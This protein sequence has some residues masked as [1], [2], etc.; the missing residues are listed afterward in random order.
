MSNRLTHG[1]SGWVKDALPSVGK[2]V[3]LALALAL[4]GGLPLV[5]LP[6]WRA[7]DT[8]ASV[9][10]EFDYMV[11]GPAK[12]ITLSTPTHHPESLTFGRVGLE[13]DPAGHATSS[14]DLGVLTWSLEFERTGR[15]NPAA[16]GSALWIFE[17]STELERANLED[18]VR[19]AP[20]W[21]LRSHTN[22]TAGVAV[23]AREDSTEPLRAT[24][25]GSKVRLRL[26][27]HPRG[28]IAWVFVNGRHQE[29]D[30][31]A[32][33][34]SPDRGSAVFQV[35]ESWLSRPVAK[36]GTAQLPLSRDVLKVGSFQLNVFPEGRL[37]IGK[38]TLG[39]L[40]LEV[41]RTNQVTIPVALRS[42]PSRATLSLMTFVGLAVP[43][44]LTARVWTQNTKARVG[45]VLLCQATV[46]AALSGFWTCVFFPALMSPDSLTQWNEALANQYDTWF[47][48]LM[49]MLMHST[50]RISDNPAFFAFCQGSIFWFSLFFCLWSVCPRPRPWLVGTGLLA[51]NPVLWSYTSVLWKDVWTA[52][53]A[54]MTA[55]FAALFLRT[56]ERRHLVA[57]IVAT[58]LAVSFRHNAVLL[59]MVP[60]ALVFR[61]TSWELPARTALALVVCGTLWIFPTLF[62]LPRNVQ[63]TPLKGAAFIEQYVG[64]LVHLKA[65]HPPEYTEEASHFDQHFGGGAA[66][67]AMAGYD[68]TMPASHLLWPGPQRAAILSAPTM[69][70]H[71]LFIMSRIVRLALRHPSGYLRHRWLN[72]RALLQIDAV[73]YPFHRGIDPNALGLSERSLLPR[74]QRAV[75]R[76]MSDKRVTDLLARHFVFVLL[77]LPALAVLWRA[78]SSPSLAVG[79]VGFVYLSSLLICDVSREWRFLLTTYCCSLLV[80]YVAALSLFNRS[81]L[82]VG[83]GSTPAPDLASKQGSPHS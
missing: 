54:L 14:N 68:P 8:P 1:W 76:V 81:P 55:A 2:R 32:G 15:K 49:A 26:R 61:A 13:P 7:D 71:F 67:Q 21:E 57:C 47:P 75:F 64:L 33:P 66:Q 35:D 42:L 51:A 9:D 69:N 77:T 48:P 45:E 41:Q 38:A 79:G 5:L 25:R 6:Q 43:L 29:L 30:L 65:G 39:G 34:G 53:F 20:G 19:S 28:G 10:L 59:A 16:L 63:R 82:E 74:V 80:S 12:E 56:R 22:G 44:F 83:L 78:R 46:A 17:L 31:F 70:E 72:V 50:Q 24:L 27:R 18:L 62:E 52:A 4:A 11:D 23:V 58:A 73:H 3:P 37:S 40:P 60:A 36:R